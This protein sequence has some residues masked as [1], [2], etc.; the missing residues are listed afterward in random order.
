MKAYYSRF[1][2]VIKGNETMILPD[3]DKNQSHL[4]SRYF[5]GIIIETT[6]DTA[7]ARIKKSSWKQFPVDTTITLDKYNFWPN[8]SIKEVSSQLTLFE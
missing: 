4:G 1:Y 3:L 5:Y 7:T 8:N 2:K 6:R